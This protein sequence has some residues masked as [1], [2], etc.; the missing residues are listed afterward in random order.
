MF[1][2]IAVIVVV[3]GA[4]VAAILRDMKRHPERDWHAAVGAL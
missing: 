1:I 3:I 2:A 4:V